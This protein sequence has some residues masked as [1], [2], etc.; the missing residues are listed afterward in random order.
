MTEYLVRNFITIETNQDQNK[1]TYASNYL[2][3]LVNKYFDV[4]KRN[5]AVVDKVL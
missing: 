2:I 1:T 5:K 3:D 4:I